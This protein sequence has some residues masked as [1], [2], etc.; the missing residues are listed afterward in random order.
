M[1]AIRDKLIS[2]AETEYKAFSLKLLPGMEP[3]RML[4][5]RLPRLRSI[6]KEIARGDWQ[7]YLEE[8]GHDYFEEIMLE[9]M[10]IGY[11]TEPLGIILPLIES[12]LSKID[13]WSVCDSFV[14]GLKIAKREQ[15]AFLALLLKCIEDGRVYHLRFVLV[16]LLNYYTAREYHKTAFDL[17]GKISHEDYYVKMAKAWALSVL[18]FHAPEDVMLFL[19]DERDPFVYNMTLQKIIESNRST[20]ELKEKIRKLKKTSK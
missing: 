3:D 11:L 8:Q 12:F 19:K 6:A 5:I 9:G 18:Y 17:L 4:G 13:N 7:D 10:V 15:E 20:K 14:N 16:M 2:L 1:N